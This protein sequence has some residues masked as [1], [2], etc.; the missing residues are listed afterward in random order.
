MSAIKI[1]GHI[2]RFRIFFLSLHNSKRFLIIGIGLNIKSNPIIDNTY[3]ATNIFFE[4][5]NEPKIKEVI[6]LI[7]L[8]YENFFL[9]LNSFSY[10]NFKKKAEAMSIK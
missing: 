3:K 7:I 5:K 2:K 8:S 6:K 1:V 9:K 4:T 10:K